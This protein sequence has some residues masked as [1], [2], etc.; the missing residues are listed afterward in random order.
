[1]GEL[2]VFKITG[3]CSFEGE[4]DDAPCMCFPEVCMECL[5]DNCE[6][7]VLYDGELEEDEFSE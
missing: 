7:F 3:M 1:M 6:F 2:R 4:E 5:T